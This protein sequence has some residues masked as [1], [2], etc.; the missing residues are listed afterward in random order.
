MKSKLFAAAISLMLVTSCSTAEPAEVSTSSPPASSTTAPAVT[1][2][3]VPRPGPGTEVDLYDVSDLFQ[4]ARNGVVSV[5]QERVRLDLFG[6]PEEVPA[7]A[8]TGI[9]VD[10]EGLVLTNFHVIEGATKVIVT[11]V[12]GRQRAAEVVA[13][14][15]SRDLALLRLEDFEGLEP[16]P[17]G[18]VD[19]IEVGDPVIAIGNAL[20]LDSADPTVSAGIVSAIGRTIRTPLGTMQELVQTD[21]AIN[22]GNSGG[23][24]LSAAGEVIGVN[25]AI[26]GNAQNIGFAISVDTAARFIDRFRLG[27]GEPY[28]GVQLVDNSPAAAERFELGTDRGA[29]VIDVVS[30]SPAAQAGLERWDVLVR[31]GEDATDNSEA[32]ILAILDTAPGETVEVE[33]YR[34][35]RLITLDVTIGERPRGT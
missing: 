35:D 3:A 27:V 29:L 22:P 25:T 19:D 17:L 5:T 30:S 32:A 18:S 24:L 26:A 4:Q 2:S 8:G 21:A 10:S 28:L 31:I 12:D 7:G 34:G 14:A 20:G 33:L 23:P 16:L 6:V 1:T 9:V 11:G 15:S 13:E